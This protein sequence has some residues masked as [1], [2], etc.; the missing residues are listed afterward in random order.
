MTHA[1]IIEASAAYS[2]NSNVHGPYCKCTRGVFIR[3]VI[4]L[5]GLWPWKCLLF[6]AIET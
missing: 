3:S 2:L 6:Y 5:L 4:R 1:E